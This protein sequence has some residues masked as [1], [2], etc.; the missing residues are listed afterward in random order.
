[1]SK[2]LKEHSNNL[3][4]R[5]PSKRNDRKQSKEDESNDTTLKPDQDHDYLLNVSKIADK[6]LEP[7]I[8]RVKILSLED[9]LKRKDVIVQEKEEE[10]NVSRF[11]LGEEAKR[12]AAY[13]MELQNQE[14]R[15]L[16]VT[17]ERD[18]NK[19]LLDQYRET[20][21]TRPEVYSSSTVKLE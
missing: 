2:E 7:S 17:K 5:E 4:L 1:M 6:S 21:R 10:S 11:E 13:E 12:R 16:Q 9:E 18:E 14:K 8:L 19:E 20:M 15:I 3:E